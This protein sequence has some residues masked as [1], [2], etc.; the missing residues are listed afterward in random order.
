[1]DT[2]DI[3]V[4]IP[5]FNEENFIESCLGGLIKQK[6]S[7]NFEVLIIDGGSKD[8]TVEQAKKIQTQ[9]IS[10]NI[11]IKILNNPQKRT[12]FAFNIGIEQA[13]GGY[14]IIL[15]AHTK[16]PSD[17]LQK[18][19]DAIEGEPQN[20]AMAGGKLNN[21]TSK[22]NKGPFS[23]AIGYAISTFWGGGVSQYRYSN[24]RQYVE[25]APFAIYR[26]SI[27]DTVGNFDTTFP[28]G[29]DGEMSAR[30][31]KAGFRILFDPNISAN[32]YTR[33]SLKKLAKQMF[34]YGVARTK[35]IRK[36][37]TLRAVH[38]F[39]MILVSYLAAAPVLVF[40]NPLLA[41]PLAAY[42]LATFI[43]SAGRPSSLVQNFVSYATIHSMFGLGMFAGLLP[44]HQN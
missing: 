18:S 34:Q 5:T 37:K 21:V 41:T 16:I 43:Y 7:L 13:R 31:R 32:Y 39:P 26:R 27:F 44:G 8:L 28:I 33:N 9:N 6:T 17:W 19:F 40:V 20:V 24:T 10:P 15:G 42:V 1:M 30:I 38:L 36:H 2:P 4:I 23:E 25:T 11:Q 14:I 29:Q 3:T 35:I 12:P 22:E